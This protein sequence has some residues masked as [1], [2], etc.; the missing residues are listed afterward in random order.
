MMIHSPLVPL[1]DC[2]VKCFEGPSRHTH[3]KSVRMKIVLQSA[4]SMNLETPNARL[5]RPSC[6]SPPLPIL[7]RCDAVTAWN[8]EE[9]K[10]EKQQQMYVPPSPPKRRR[11]LPITTLRFAQT[12]PLVSCKRRTASLIW[13]LGSIQWGYNRS[14]SSSS[15]RKTESV[16]VYAAA[17]FRGKCPP[18]PLWDRL[19]CRSHRRHT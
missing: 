19:W 13:S 4:M 18:T 10:R 5:S 9:R 11:M 1:H 3:P 8:E 12:K 17:L 2:V 14:T 15:Q 6:S 7:D 16:R